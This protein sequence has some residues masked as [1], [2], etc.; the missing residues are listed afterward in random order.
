MNTSE[1]LDFLSD[2]LLDDERIVSI[3]EREFLADLLRHSENN[4]HESTPEVTRRLLGL[5]AKL[6]LNELAVY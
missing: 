1:S 2:V 6:L 3:D 4:P 5:P